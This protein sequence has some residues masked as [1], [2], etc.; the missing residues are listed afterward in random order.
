MRARIRVLVPLALWLPGSAAAEG[1]ACPPGPD[2]LS[3]QVFASI[4]TDPAK[5]LYTY[6]YAVA[7]DPSSAQQVKYFAVDVVPP[8]SGIASPGGWQGKVLKIR[9]WVQWRAFLLADPDRVTNDGYVP[10]SIAQIRPGASLGGFSF[11]S[12]KPPGAAAYHASGFVQF[13]VATGATPAEAELAA[14]QMAEWIDANCPQLARPL[15]DQGVTGPTIG[16]VDATP[17]RIDLKPG[18]H[19][20][21]VNPR[22]QGVT[23]VAILGS[24]SLDVRS[25]D[26]SSIRL[27]PSGAAPRDAGRFED[28]NGDGTPD[29]LLHFPTPAIGLRCG[30][31][32]VVLAATTRTGARL[33]GFDSIVTVGCR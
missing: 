25:V 28:V 17:I 29:L 12:P 11:Q 4:R 30:D 13:P 21:P 18:D 5:P 14:E 26:P 2:Q 32:V 3:L 20:N 27:V 31:A 8:V 16:P 23:P 19:T 33:A 6:S 1:L 15:I 22:S 10:P 24:P 7:S 9:P